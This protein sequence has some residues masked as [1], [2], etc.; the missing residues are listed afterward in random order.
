MRKFT[1]SPCITR[2]GTIITAHEGGQLW[3]RPEPPTK[4]FTIHR[5]GTN[6]ASAD[7]RDQGSRAHPAMRV[8]S[9]YR[10]V[11]PRERKV[12]VSEMFPGVLQNQVP[13]ELPAHW[14][15]IDSMGCRCT[16]ST[17]VS[18]PSYGDVGEHRDRRN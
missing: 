6:I 2:E 1:L 12:H 11:N 7:I 13:K 9:Y 4:L 14:E 5:R 15:G 10:T 18:G 3:R 16:R 17:T 8:V